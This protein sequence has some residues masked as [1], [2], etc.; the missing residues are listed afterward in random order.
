MHSVLINDCW[1][2]L[3]I[4]RRAAPICFVAYRP[5]DR[6]IIPNKRTR[7]ISIN[8]MSQSRIEYR[9]FS[10][11]RCAP[12]IQSNRQVE[13]IISDRFIVDASWCH[14][15][16]YSFHFPERLNVQHQSISK[17]LLHCEM[18]WI[19]RADLFNLIFSIYPFEPIEPVE[20]L[21]FRTHRQCCCKLLQIDANSCWQVLMNPFHLPI[22]LHA[23]YILSFFSFDFLFVLLRCDNSMQQLDAATRCSNSMQSTARNCWTASPSWKLATCVRLDGSSGASSASR[24]PIK[25]FE[26]FFRI[27]LEPAIE[28]P[29]SHRS[30]QSIPTETLLDWFLCGGAWNTSPE[31]P[32]ESSPSISTQELSL[33]NLKNLLFPSTESVREIPTDPTRYPSR[34]SLVLDQDQDRQ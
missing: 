20:S 7:Q 16:W 9:A 2:P 22:P 30:A 17:Y 21:S 19:K 5:D 6:L 10:K 34:A 4:S 13:S 14:H 1:T 27:H 11:K 33:N 26:T 31:H 8:Q 24:N 32:R 29:S 28:L 23:G 18:N 12:F 3:Q 25:I 15:L